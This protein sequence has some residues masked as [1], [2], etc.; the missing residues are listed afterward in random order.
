VALPLG[1]DQAAS[2]RVRLVLR[3]PSW[4]APP[5]ERV[6]ELALV[7]RVMATVAGPGISARAA[8]WVL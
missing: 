7:P 6:P 8:A 5:V 1:A 4:A 3:L 2:R